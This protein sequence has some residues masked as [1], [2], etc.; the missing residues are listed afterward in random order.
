MAVYKVPQDVEAE[1]KL[2]G[3]FS[4]RQFIYLI[5]VAISIAIA[6]GLSRLL[7]P[8]A[9]VPL[10]LILFFGALALPLKK[11]QPM[12]IYLAAVV[13]FYL[14]PRKRLWQPDG[15]Q[16]LVEITAPKLIEIKRSKD[17]SEAEAQQRLSY[18]ANIVDTEGWAV[19]GVDTTNSAMQN[20]AYYEA[21]Q[22][23]DVLDASSGVAQSFDSMINQ[24]DLKR[25]QEV[26]ERMHQPPQQAA[27]PAI[28]TPPVFNP[29]A[30]LTSAA[31]PPPEEPHLTYNPYPDSIHQ[32]VVNPL[33]TEPQ[34]Q[35]QAPTPP[36]TTQAAPQ[37]QPEAPAVDNTETTTSEKPVSPDIINLAN[38]SDLS[39]ETIAHEANRIHQKEEQ[40]PEQEVVISLR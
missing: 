19:R 3:P 25:R 37:P 6:W 10:P 28:A 39:I 1:D 16:S 36:P 12:E 30:S 11:D 40:L 5:I 38:N 23:E 13:S 7:L 27:P 32:S 15:I 24:S 33:G 9:I 8:L 21:Q 26:V 35:M 17:L 22:Q 20:D 2:I 18:L 34:P 14:K 29:Y 31:T 4:F